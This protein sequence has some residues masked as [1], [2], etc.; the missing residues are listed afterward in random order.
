[1]TEKKER[2]CIAWA[3]KEINELIANEFS[4]DTI[5]NKV[6]IDKLNN[7]LTAY[8]SLYKTAFLNFKDFEKEYMIRLIE[9]KPLTPITENDFEDF[10][11]E[12]NDPN[13]D[14]YI[15][16]NKGSLIFK[17]VNK[18]TGN[19]TYNDI[20]RFEYVN[21]NE[22]DGTVFNYKRIRDIVGTYL[23]REYPITMPYLPK[24]K[25]D[26]VLISAMNNNSIIHI[27]RIVDMNNGNEYCIDVDI[28][29][30]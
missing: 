18:T 15:S 16:K 13:E 28:P 26:L 27:H 9:R 5:D 29:V 22:M 30:D 25:A 4:E 10:T 17:L 14:C 7:V 8:K 3:E 24:T 11:V 20:Y 21:V 19:V 1:M 2:G 12:C 6:N 23:N